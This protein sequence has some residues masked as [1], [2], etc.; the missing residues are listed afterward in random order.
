[1]KVEFE[2]LEDKINQLKIELIQIA[3]ATG[4]NS[5]ATLYCSQELDKHITIYQR[6]LQYPSMK[7]S[8]K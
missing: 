3:E 4:L 8:V 7:A 2:K 1:M 5:H 6:Y